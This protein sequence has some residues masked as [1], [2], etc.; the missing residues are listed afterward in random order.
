MVIMIT[1][2]TTMPLMS[3]AR[4]AAAATTMATTITPITITGTTTSRH[5]M[6]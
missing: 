5:E 2:A 6:C 1:P 4:I 3:T